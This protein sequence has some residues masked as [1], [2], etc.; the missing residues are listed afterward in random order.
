[1]RLETRFKIDKKKNEFYFLAAR[2]IF[3]TQK[4]NAHVRG[5]TKK[6]IA[7]TDLSRC[8]G[9][10]IRNHSSELICMISSCVQS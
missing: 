5:R 3:L 6:L 4:G 1:L 7:P 8:L 10:S 9:A 2:K